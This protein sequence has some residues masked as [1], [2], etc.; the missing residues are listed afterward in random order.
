MSEPPRSWG[1]S[2]VSFAFAVLAAS[3]ALQLAAG[4]LLEAL[5]VLA[6]VAGVMVIGWCVWRYYNRS[7]GW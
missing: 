1:A 7:R 6:V 2:I 3:V 4:F 5:P